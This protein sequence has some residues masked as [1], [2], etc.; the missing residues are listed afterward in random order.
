MEQT[1]LQPTGEEP[2]P[3]SFGTETI[4]AILAVSILTLFSSASLALQGGVE[5]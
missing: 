2:Q 3:A 5:R 1:V 4:V